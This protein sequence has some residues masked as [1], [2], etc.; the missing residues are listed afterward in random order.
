MRARLA[1]V[2]GLAAA[3]ALASPR[4]PRAQTAAPGD[5]AVEEARVRFQ[6]GVQ[7]FR[8]GS[9]EAALAEFQKANQIAPSY[10][11]L[12]N[13]AQVQF[14]LHD[15]VA[16]LRSFRRYLAE[17]GAEVPADRR[18]K[19]TTEIRELEGRVATVEIVT[20]VEGAS[21]LVDDVVVGTSP[22]DDPLLVNAGLRR[23]SA[24]KPGYVPAAQ[25]LTIAGGERATVK[26]ALLAVA[27]PAPGTPAAAGPAPALRQA[28]RAAPAPAAGPSRAAAWI[29]LGVT[30]ALAIGTGIAAFMTRDAKSTFDDQLMRLPG[31]RTRIDD[32][33]ARLKSWAAVTD[34]LAAATLVATGFTIYLATAGGDRREAGPARG[35]GVAVAPTLGGVA[36][37]GRF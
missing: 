36:V 3:L 32:A 23:L 18:T 11:L 17:G 9:F 10:R 35:A 7:L 37:S 24:A 12:Y 25:N 1:T 4:A 33:R 31:D 30:G 14:E 19:V 21:V 27:E 8:E 6:R 34:G 26:L 20:S 2:V 29:S 15:Y 22:L 5:A 13:I 16:A 28:T